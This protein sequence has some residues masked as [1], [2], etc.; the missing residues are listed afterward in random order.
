[1][2]GETDGDS[3]MADSEGES[4]SGGE[5]DGSVPECSSVIWP[6]RVSHCRSVPSREEETRVESLPGRYLRH[7]HA[8]I[9]VR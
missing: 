7:G 3:R 2:R 4:E 5:G 6:E 1:M 8:A 9:P